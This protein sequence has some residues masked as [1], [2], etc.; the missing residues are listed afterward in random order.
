MI[1]VNPAI[2]TLINSKISQEIYRSL[3]LSGNEKTIL[4]N[5][6]IVSFDTG[7]WDF[8]VSSNFSTASITLSGNSLLV[9]T[10]LP[11]DYIHYDPGEIPLGVLLKTNK[12]G[13][14]TVYS[15]FLLDVNM[16][17]TSSGGS[18][19]MSGGLGLVLPVGASVG[20]T[21][22]WYYNLL[23]RRKYFRNIYDSYSFYAPLIIGAT[24]KAPLLIEESKANY[25]LE[26][27]RDQSFNFVL[28]YD[29][30][31]SVNE[32]NTFF[33]INGILLTAIRITE[34]LKQVGFCLLY[35]YDNLIYNDTYTREEV[36][37]KI[38]KFRLVGLS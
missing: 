35:R 9:G 25:N 17:L 8:D 34:S 10:G 3:T 21:D 38:T 14:I 27:L 12:G 29:N 30:T 28:Y 19:I 32:A 23:G 7:D 20:D 36:F 24:Y 13:D 5:N 31:R 6:P 1:S 16:K 37:Y 4:K 2:P 22:D 33:F 26:F 18:S 11:T 15:K